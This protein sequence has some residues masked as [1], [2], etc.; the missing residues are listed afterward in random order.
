MEFDAALDDLPRHFARDGDIVGSH[1]LTVLSSVFPDGEDFFVRSVEAVRDRIDDPRLRED[2]EGFVGQESMHG[3]EHRVLNERL[4]ELGYPTEAIGVYI[5]T[6]LRWRE[7]IQSTKFNLAVTAALEHYTATLAETLLG[8]A[9]ARDEIGHDGVRHLLMWHALEEA[10]HKAVAFDVYRA[11]GGSE[12][13][14]KAAMWVVHLNFIFET[15]V[16]TAISVAMDRDARRHP[17]RVLRGLGRLT[18]SPFTQRRTVRQL[19]QYHHRDFHPNDRDTT[20]LIADWRAEL[21][22]SG[23]RLTELRAS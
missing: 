22:G 8:D 21:F 14:R 20:Q 23:G 15:G 17:L 4:G 3:K 10:E 2:V 13:M 6:T 18:H 5:R 12:R 16:W 9:A 19:F 11:V 1:V 7:R